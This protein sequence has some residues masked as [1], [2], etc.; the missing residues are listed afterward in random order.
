M[1]VADLRREFFDL[2]IDQRV[3][4]VVNFDVDAIC[5]VKILQ[6]LL[7]C[8]HIMHTVIPVRG[9]SDLIQT[10]EEHFSHR[11]QQEND[12]GGSDEED[13]I[14]S[15]PSFRRVVLI[16]CGGTIDLVDFLDPPPDVIIFVADSHKPTDVCNI[17]SDGQVR[18]LNRQE[19]DEGNGRRS[20]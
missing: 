14:G 10:F 13:E 18:L 3:L 11:G 15:R 20:R 5:S 4:V 12:D 9:K 17:Y 6:T 2:L 8:D 7:R 1:Y 16:N 19:D